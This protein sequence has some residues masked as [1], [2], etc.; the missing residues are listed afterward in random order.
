MNTDRPIIR[1]KVLLSV[2]SL[3][4]ID[5]SLLHS[6]G[7]ELPKRVRDSDDGV[8]GAAVSLCVSLHNVRC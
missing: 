5:L 4:S 1:R 7:P 8:V 3:G 2:R 6:L